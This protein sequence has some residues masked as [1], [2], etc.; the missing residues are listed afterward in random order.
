[1]GISGY[2]VGLFGGFQWNNPLTAFGSLSTSVLLSSIIAIACFLAAGIFINMYY[3]KSSAVGAMSK[4]WKF[5]FIGLILSGFYQILK[6]P[7]TYE[8]IY[9]DVFVAIFLIFQVAVTGV[10]V[11]GLYLLKK[12]VTI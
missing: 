10:L 4:G 12:E 11:Y 9:G 8:W 2:V 1:M 6:I 7:Y 3:K 5:F